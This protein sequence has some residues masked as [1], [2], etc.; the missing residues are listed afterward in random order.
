MGTQKAWGARGAQGARGARGAQGA[1][2]ARGAW[3][4]GLEREGVESDW[5]TA[6]RA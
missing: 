4:F 5:F 3:E 2:G 1:L 6:P